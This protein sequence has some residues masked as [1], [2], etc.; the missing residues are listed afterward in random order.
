MINT[1]NA[2]EKLKS[3]IQNQNTNTLRALDTSKVS[4]DDEYYDKRYQMVQ[5]YNIIYAKN[6]EPLFI[7]A[8]S[9]ILTL[10]I[11]SIV[12]L[13]PIIP[14]IFSIAVSIRNEKEKINSKFY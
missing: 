1:K 2:L 10:F 8:L 9:Y 7:K 5:F 4:F 12:V 3:N 11:A 14:L 13:F 6:Y